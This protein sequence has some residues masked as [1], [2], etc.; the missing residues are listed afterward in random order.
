M[1]LSNGINIVKIKYKKNSEQK[2]IRDGI[3]KIADTCILEKKYTLISS[4]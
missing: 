4:F 2:K 1:H 3:K